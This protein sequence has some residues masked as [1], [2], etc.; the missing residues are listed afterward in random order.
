MTKNNQ[1]CSQDVSLAFVIKHSIEPKYI[2]L[3]DFG[4]GDREKK[5]NTDNK[6]NRKKKKLL[7]TQYARR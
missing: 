5:Q 7:M 2:Y 4:I 3:K 6:N 1:K